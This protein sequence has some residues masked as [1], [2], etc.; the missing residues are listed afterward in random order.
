MTDKPRIITLKKNTELF[1]NDHTEVKQ[2][3][4]KKAGDK[5]SYQKDVTPGLSVHTCWALVPAF[6]GD[7]FP[8]KYIKTHIEYH[9]PLVVIDNDT[10]PPPGSIVLTQGRHEGE[11]TEV[12]DLEGPFG[13]TFFKVEHTEGPL[14]GTYTYTKSIQVLKVAKIKVK[15]SKKTPK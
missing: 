2:S 1:Y 9:Y 3:V 11:F 4:I 14:T 12:V 10:P 7:K 5:V 8:R 15:K 13:G 6:P